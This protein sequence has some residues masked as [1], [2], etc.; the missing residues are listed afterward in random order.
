MSETHLI[1]ADGVLDI[2]VSSPIIKLLSPEA[3]AVARRS[4]AQQHRLAY[5][6]LGD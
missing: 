2:E 1:G 3:S 6:S 4:E 5:N